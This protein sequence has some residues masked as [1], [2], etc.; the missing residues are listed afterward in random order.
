MKKGEVVRHKSIPELP[1]VVVN[2]N[3]QGNVDCSWYN[4]ITGDF[5]QA[6]FYPEEL[7]VK[8]ESEG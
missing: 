5:S 1:M 6:T 2:V 3:P 4:G 7:V 8:T